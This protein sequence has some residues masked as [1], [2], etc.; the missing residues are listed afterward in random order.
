MGGSEGYQQGHGGC[1]AS[2]TLIV[3]FGVY[4]REFAILFFLIKG[5]WKSGSLVINQQ[6]AFNR[7]S[8]LNMRVG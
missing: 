1:G 6:S 8:T 2:F 7:L 3:D 4:I 5:G